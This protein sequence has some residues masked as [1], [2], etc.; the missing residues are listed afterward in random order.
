VQAYGH[1]GLDRDEFARLVEDSFAT[2]QER[3]A[4]R[5][6]LVAAVMVLCSAPSPSSCGSEDM[7][8]WPAA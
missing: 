3:V 4:N 1:E 6:R 2:A 8:C 5:A 7:T